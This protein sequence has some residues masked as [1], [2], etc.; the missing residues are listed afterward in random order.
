MQLLRSD[1]VGDGDIG[2][3]EMNYAECSQMVSDYMKYIC[4]HHGVTV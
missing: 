3:G 4:I 1:R 2:A